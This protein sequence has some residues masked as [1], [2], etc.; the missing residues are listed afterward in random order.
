MDEICRMSKWWVCHILAY[1]LWREKGTPFVTIWG[2]WI[3]LGEINEYSFNKKLL[4]AFENVT[5]VLCKLNNL[6]IALNSWKMI[7]ISLTR[8]WSRG[9]I[10]ILPVEFNFSKISK[11]FGKYVLEGLKILR[12]NARRKF[13]LISI[14]MYLVLV[15]RKS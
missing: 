14:I 8:Y 5:S 11:C 6:W 2:F 13:M 1:G 10:V 4:Y 15:L 7:K 3:P 9:N 12:E